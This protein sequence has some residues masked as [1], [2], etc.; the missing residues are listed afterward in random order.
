MLDE[1]NLLLY[2]GLQIEPSVDNRFLVNAPLPIVF[3]LYNL[4]GPP[5]QWNLTAK[6]RIVDEKGKEYYF[7]PIP[8]KNAM[9]V[10]GNSEAAVA[11]SLLFKD[12]PPGKYQLVVEASE[13]ATAKTATLETDL[14]LISPNGI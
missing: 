1:S 11:L 6:A 5:D 9:S 3:R 12:A 4:S 10:S 8:L 7:G 14:E 13:A 2:A